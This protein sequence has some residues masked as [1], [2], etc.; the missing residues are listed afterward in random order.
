MMPAGQQIPQDAASSA[1]GHSTVHD[2]FVLTDEQIVEIYRIVKDAVWNGHKGA[3]PDEEF[4]ARIFARAIE[5][6]VTTSF[7]PLT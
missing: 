6:K 1:N 7:Q 5:A 2:L 4:L 3:I